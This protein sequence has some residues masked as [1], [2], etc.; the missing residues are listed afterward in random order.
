MRSADI[1]TRPLNLDGWSVLDSYLAAMENPEFP[2]AKLQ[3]RSA[4]D[5]VISVPMR[6]DQVLS[7]QISSDPGWSVYSAGRRVPTWSDKLGQMVV[8]PHCNGLCTI[9][10]KFDGSADVR[11]ARVLSPLG[12]RRRALLDTG[13][14]M[15]KAFGFNE[16]ELKMLLVAVRQMRRRRHLRGK[17]A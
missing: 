4:G 2:A 7:V 15:A 5:A 8:E 14:D 16:D 13:G 12:D 3:W 6:P 10:L 9:E 17:C 11:I 1:V